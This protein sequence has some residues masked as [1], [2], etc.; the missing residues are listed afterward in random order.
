MFF[1]EKD[2]DGSKIDYLLAISGGLRLIPQGPSLNVLEKDYT[3][4]LEDGAY[5]TPN[6]TA[7]PEQTGH[8]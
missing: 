4:M 5:P 2:I 7:I 8:T 1:S 3:A 6:W